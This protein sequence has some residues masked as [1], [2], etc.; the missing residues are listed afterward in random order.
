MQSTVAFFTT[1]AYVT[2]ALTV[3]VEMTVYLLTYL[4]LKFSHNSIRLPCSKRHKCT[5]LSTAWS[6]IETIIIICLIFIIIVYYYLFHTMKKIR[7]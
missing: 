5:A 1:R 7:K 3:R 6:H 2:F 4:L